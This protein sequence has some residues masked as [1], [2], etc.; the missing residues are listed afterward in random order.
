MPGKLEL[1]S[2]NVLASDCAILLPEGETRLD[3]DRQ[4]WIATIEE[5]DTMILSVQSFYILK[6]ISIQ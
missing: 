5:R 1:H 6:V 2:A 3:R 4:D